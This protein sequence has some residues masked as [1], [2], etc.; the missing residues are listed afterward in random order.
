MRAEIAQLHARLHTTTVYVTHDQV[1]AMTLGQRIGVM[2]RGVFEQVGTPSDLYERPANAFV[3]SFV[4]SPSMNLVQARVDGE[5]SVLFGGTRL[6]LHPLAAERLK[7]GDSVTV[8]IRPIDI[9][10]AEFARSPDNPVVEVGVRVREY[11]GWATVLMFVMDDAEALSP[12]IE[13]ADD[14]ARSIEPATAR[15]WWRKSARRAARKWADGRAFRSIPGGST[16]STSATEELIAGPCN[17][18]ATRPS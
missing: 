2:R 11:L 16:S 6:P 12:L 4:G 8:G 14:E 9:Q 17:P 5:G 1:E 18:R 10:D 13:E 15:C 7:E 3:A